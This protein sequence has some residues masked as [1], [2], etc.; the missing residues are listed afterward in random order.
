MWLLDVNLPTALAGFL[1]GQGIVAETAAARGW[2][3]LTNGALAQTAAR[4]GFDALLT[5]DRGFGAATGNVLETLPNLA[6]VIVTI[7]QAREVTYLS[8]FE[9]A[10]LR[11]PIQPA[12]GFIVEWP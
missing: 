4:C 5:R 1:R 3:Q 11:S 10:W 6:I 9:A 8:T 12:A 7:A 2:R